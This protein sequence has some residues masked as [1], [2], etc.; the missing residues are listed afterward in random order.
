MLKVE[1]KGG[2]DM[3]QLSTSE[4]LADAKTSK[5]CLRYVN[6]VHDN[7]TYCVAVVVVLNAVSVSVLCTG[8]VGQLL[9]R[10]VSCRLVAA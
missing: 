5:R 3:K 7:Y 10:T 1:V 8:V 9:A 2:S 4:R 6:F